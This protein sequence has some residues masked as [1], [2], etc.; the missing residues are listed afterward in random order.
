MSGPARHDEEITYPEDFESE[1]DDDDVEGGESS[2]VASAPT[3]MPSGP[4][5]RALQEIRHK[6]EHNFFSR[7]ELED[8]LQIFETLYDCLRPEQGTHNM[9]TIEKALFENHLF[10]EVEKRSFI[11]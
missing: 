11:K 1:D 9:N 3:A 5:G 2:L 7:S 8:K 10:L 4:Q 6:L